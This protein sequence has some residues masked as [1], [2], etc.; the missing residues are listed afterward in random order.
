VLRSWCGMG[1]CGS[2]TEAGGNEGERYLYNSPRWIRGNWKSVV[3]RTLLL[4]SLRRDGD[5]AGVA[6][7]RRRPGGEATVPGVGV[8]WG[9]RIGLARLGFGE[10][11]RVWD[12]WV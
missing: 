2:C 9:V 12:Q 5:I 10:R 4:I 11:G 6:V 7:P 8:G 3:R 1:S